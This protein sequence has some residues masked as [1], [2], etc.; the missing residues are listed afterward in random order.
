MT[1][2]VVTVDRMTPYKEITTLIAQSKISAVRVIYNGGH[3][4][5]VVSEADLL[6]VLD[7]RTRKAQLESAAA[8]TGTPAIRSTGASRRAS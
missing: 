7:K 4:A 5:G 2:S 8:S 1:T 6:S 3:L